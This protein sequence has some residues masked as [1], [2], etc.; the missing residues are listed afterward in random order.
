MRKNNGM[1][2]N[3][4]NIVSI[5]NLILVL[6]VLFMLF[7]ASLSHATVHTGPMTM[8]RLGQSAIMLADGRVLV[9]GGAAGGTAEIYDPASGVFTATAPM[10]TGRSGHVAVALADGRVLVAGGSA[11][12]VDLASAEIYDPVSATWSMTGNMVLPRR[13]AKALLLQDG[14]VLVVGGYDATGA[15]SSEVYDPLSGTFSASGS[16]PEAMSNFSLAR[17]NDGRVLFAG[18][19]AYNSGNYLSRALLWNPVGGTWAATG[20]MTAGRSHFTATTLQDGRVLVAG[21]RI[22]SGKLS[23]AEL[24]DP[25]SSTFTRTGSLTMP[26]AE[27]T[28]LL[29]ADGSVVVSGGASQYSGERTIE[30]YDVISGLWQNV[31]LLLEASLGHT[32][33]LLGNGKILTTGANSLGAS[34]TAGLYDPICATAPSSL[35]GI[36]Q[37]LPDLGGSGSVNLSVPAGC[38][39][40]VFGV[41]GWMSLDSPATGV[42]SATISYTVSRNT[43][44]YSRGSY[45]AIANLNYRIDQAQRACDVTL[46]P[47][48]TPISQ[49]FLGTGGANGRFDVSTDSAC[50]FTVSG[51]PAWVTITSGGSNR[52]GGTVYFSVAANSGSARTA[53]LVVNNARF[54]INQAASSTCDTGTIGSVILPAQN[55]AATGGSGSVTVTYPAACNW[56]VMTVPSW[57]TITSGA[58]GQGNGVVNF[59]VA[60]NTG[61]ARSHQMIAANNYVSI[62]QDAPC[63]TSGVVPVTLPNKNFPS[64]GGTG[65]IAITYPAACRWAVTGLPS[66]ITITAGATGMGNGAVNYTVAA[67]TGAARSAVAQ[68]VNNTQPFSQDMLVVGAN[69]LP[70]ALSAGVTS[71]GTLSTASCTTGARGST[72][73]TNRHSFN[74][75]AG[76][77]I[78]IQLTSSAFDSYVYL[79]DPSGKVIASDDDGGGGTNSRIPAASGTFTLPATAGTYVIEVTTYSSGRTGAYSVTY[80]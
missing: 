22:S 8:A 56:I 57:I 41:P 12:N 69:C 35:S 42:G 15:A 2:L 45:L 52:G 30:R 68:F 73:Y 4:R 27:Q 71:S 20:S 28:A 11:N 67:N 78:S 48:L 38:G 5:Q 34:A 23:G 72:Y 43:T 51:M 6:I 80:N 39:W 10:S 9:V 58:T 53:T 26:L 54:T 79:K 63:D 76:Q 19:F 65:S 18:G 50:S 1:M 40:E 44:D 47:V 66:W 74:G 70:G 37:A 32:M 49:S 36:G 59:T 24:Y 31:G 62:N 29:M 7:S 60:P 33:T 61:A 21:G 16:L 75:V 55:F 13:T 64:S 25:V 17:L 77:K 3:K 46:V 14:R